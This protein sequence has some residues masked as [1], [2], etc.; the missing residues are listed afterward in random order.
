MKVTNNSN[1][2]NFSVGFEI[3]LVRYIMQ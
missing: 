2:Y 3:D 1:Q